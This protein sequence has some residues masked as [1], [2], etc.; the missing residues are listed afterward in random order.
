M[1]K[2]RRNQTEKILLDGERILYTYRPNL[3]PSVSTTLLVWL[4]FSGF[5][6]IFFVLFPL[7]QGFPRDMLFMQIGFGAM[8]ALFFFGI[9]LVQI[10]AFRNA[11][12][13]VTNKRF[14]IQ[15]GIF[16]ID[17]ASIMLADV[18]FMAV[19]VSAFDKMMRKGTGSVTFATKALPMVSSKTSKF[20]FQ[21]IPDVYENYKLFKRLSDDAK[22]F[23]DDYPAFR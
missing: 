23:K 9:L 6:F 16:G 3:L 14:I 2:H 22:R 17:Y 10:L 4:F 15:K 13:S 12:Y 18:E 1:D 20:V 21:N 19:D 7:T 8:M 11:F 5:F